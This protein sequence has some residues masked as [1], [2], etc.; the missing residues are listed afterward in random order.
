MLYTFIG[1]TFRALQISKT[2]PNKWREREIGGFGRIRYQ[3]CFLFIERIGVLN[4]QSP[5]ICRSYSPKCRKNCYLFVC[6]IKKQK[7]R[8]ICITV[9][10]LI[11]SVNQS[12]ELRSSKAD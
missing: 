12:I 9:Q 8:V 10:Q 1:C 4:E 6:G 2:W 7:Y 3:I 11:Q 5:E